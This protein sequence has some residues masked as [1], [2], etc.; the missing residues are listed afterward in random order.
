MGLQE[1]PIYFAGTLYACLRGLVLLCNSTLKRYADSF[2]L[3]FFFFFLPFLWYSFMIIYWQGVSQC[4]QFFFAKSE[5][6]H[7]CWGISG[8]MIS[9]C[10]A[11]AA[12]G[13]KC[14]PLSLDHS[15]RVSLLLWWVLPSSSKFLAHVLLRPASLSLIALTAQASMCPAAM[16]AQGTRCPPLF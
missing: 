6:L 5:Y 1:D 9:D 4:Q 8:N 7:K 15:P 10:Q 2:I 14:L 16:C 12:P 3:D 11:G 13:Q